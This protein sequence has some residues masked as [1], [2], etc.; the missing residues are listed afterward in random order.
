MNYQNLLEKYH[1]LVAENDSLR[2]ENAWLKVK[3]CNICPSH[4]YENIMIH[5]TDVKDQIDVNKYKYLQQNR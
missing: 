4:D 1:A 2:K 3:L 5:P